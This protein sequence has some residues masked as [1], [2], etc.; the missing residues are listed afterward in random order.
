MKH[1]IRSKTDPIEREI[2]LALRPGIFIAYNGGF[3]FVTN[4]GEAAGRIDRLIDT[5]PARAV[6]LYETFLA[7]C[8]AKANELD[9]SDGTFGDFAQDLICRWIKARQAAGAEADRTASTLLAWMDDDSYAFCH[10]IEEHAAAA[11]AHRSLQF[12]RSIQARCSRLS[13]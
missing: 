3:P 12:S 10:K 1:R 5:E 7:G 13:A 4:L 11:R 6:G 2:E 8:H 9:D